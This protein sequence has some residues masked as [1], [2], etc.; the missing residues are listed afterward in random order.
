M[1]SGFNLSDFKTRINS[2]GRKQYFEIIIPSITSFIE[3]S[4]DFIT[5]MCRSTTMPSM[6]QAVNEVH[7]RGV[8]MK[9]NARAMYDPWEVTFLSDEGQQLR[10]SLM[11]WMRL[12]CNVSQLVNYEQE[13]Y[14]VDNV[15]VRK[16]NAKK[17]VMT[18]INFF[19][20]WPTQVS[21]VEL[22]QEGG[23]VETFNV[24]FTYD[25]WLLDNEIGQLNGTDVNVDY[26][27]KGVL[28][29][30]DVFESIY[31]IVAPGGSSF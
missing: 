14:K 3:G 12:A 30:Q 4:N 16:L 20:I 5:A 17:Q 22:S 8:P 26:V 10:N 2:I 28:S 1:P 6:T 21:E 27:G 11:S 9:L 31:E 18:T 23:G 29:E 19:G 25:F 24:T 13:D 7:H 15:I